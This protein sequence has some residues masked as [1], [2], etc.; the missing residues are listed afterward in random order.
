MKRS[1]AYHPQ[2]DGQTEIVNKCLETYLRCFCYDSPRI[3]GQWLSWAKY[4]YNTTFHASLGTTPF[5]VVYGRVPPPLLS[6][7]IH[8]TANDTLD[9]QLQD[10]DQALHLLKEN[11]SKAQGRMKKYADV[12]RTE[13]EFDVGDLVLLKIRPYRQKTL[14]KRRNEKLSAKIFGPV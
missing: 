9:R 11:L 4:W 14:A 13:R 7:G 1:T 5:Q 8:R 10:R 12:K 3:R 6:Y 2:T